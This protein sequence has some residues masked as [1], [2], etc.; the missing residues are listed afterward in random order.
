M[1]K[2]EREHRKKV[3]SRNE[4]MG[5]GNPIARKMVAAA[6]R[7]GVVNELRKAS[8][9]DQIDVLNRTVAG[10][11]PSKLREAIQKKAPGEMDKGIKKLR[12]EG[13]EVTVDILCAEIKSTP[14]FLKMCENAGLS[15]EWFES[16]AKKRMEAHG[17]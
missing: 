6:S 14:G 13:K 10:Q 3:A 2:K 7:Q 1:G 16:L 9:E 15:L 12:K 17:L 4:R 11:H 5:L 8:T